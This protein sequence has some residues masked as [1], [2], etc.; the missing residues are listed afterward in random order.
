MR[1]LLEHV[2]ALAL[3]VLSR[4]GVSERLSALSV[5]VPAE[6]RPFWAAVLASSAVFL[7]H[8]ALASGGDIRVRVHRALALLLGLATPVAAAQALAS[9]LDDAFAGGL[10]LLVLAGGLLHRALSGVRRAGAAERAVL[11]VRGGLEAAGLGLL[12]TAAF[13]VAT[14]REVPLRLAFWGLFLL[15]LSI[16][17]L[18]D[19]SAL[20]ARTG[21]SGSAARDLKAAAGASKGK[22]RPPPAR[23]FSRGLTGL[24]KALLLVAWLALPLAA[25]L[26]PGEVAAGTWPRETLVLSAY[27]PLA[28]GL[29]AVVLLAGGARDLGSRPVAGLRGLLAGA[30]TGA[31]LLKVYLDPSFAAY[32]ASL[33][34]LVLFETL[35]G[36]LLGT[37]SRER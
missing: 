30:A 26:A 24:A 15:R 6:A 7:L 37:V 36:F 28:L 22:K 10:L 4:P 11:L 9:P 3:H 34:G 31:Y 29:T 20:A 12:G 35:A 2:W 5:P 14:G 1:E 33:A 16:A 13:L 8:A 21:L 27:P 19:P 23:R 32:R 18:V 17:D 25:A